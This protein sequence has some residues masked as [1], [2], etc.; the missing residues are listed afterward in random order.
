[1][2]DTLAGRFMSADPV[3]QAP[4]WSQGLNRYAYVFNDPINLVDPSG[5]EAAA[6]GGGLIGGLALG[7]LGNVAVQG[8]GMMSAGSLGAGAIGLGGFG[9]TLAGGIGFGSSGSTTG[10]MGLGASAPT[11]VPATQGGMNATGQNTG[12]EAPV[13]EGIPALDGSIP[14]NLRGPDERLAMIPCG[15]DLRCPTALDA[16][17][18]PGG[19]VVSAGTQVGGRLLFNLLRGLIPRAL[20]GEIAVTTRGL[21]HVLERHIIGGARTAGK[22]IFSSGTNIHQIVKAAEAVKPIAQSN[23]NYREDSERGPCHRY[24]I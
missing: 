17:F 22:S 5:F 4:Y 1:M 11:S 7:G 3:T 9:V 16:A 6:G 8:I 10:R 23:G 2:Y 21:T 19:V 24:D 18:L 13:Q 14:E 20:S 15:P 12:V